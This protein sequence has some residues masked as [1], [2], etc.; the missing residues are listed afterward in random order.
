VQ[1]LP[2]DGLRRPHEGH[3]IPSE[4]PQLPQNLASAG[5]EAPH[6]PHTAATSMIADATP[7]TRSGRTPVRRV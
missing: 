6:A 3:A 5:L 7:G 1:N 4:A 2:S